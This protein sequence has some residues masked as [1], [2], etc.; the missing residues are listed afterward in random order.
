[1]AGDESRVHTADSRQESD[2]VEAAGT[3]ETEGAGVCLTRGRLRHVVAGTR[4]RHCCVCPF[5]NTALRLSVR[6]Y[7]MA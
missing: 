1:M 4:G 5:H 6:A 3:S 7:S 2:S